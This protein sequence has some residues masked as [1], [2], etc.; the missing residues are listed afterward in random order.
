MDDYPS[1]PY[2]DNAFLQKSEDQKKEEKKEQSYVTSSLPV[3]E[4]F[5]TWLQE[6]ADFYNSTEALNVTEKTP[7]RQI[8]V[9]VLLKKGMHREFT[10]K[11][12]EF[13]TDFAEYLKEELK[14]QADD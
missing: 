2:D 11:I 14:E 5:I 8:A 12:E 7:E 10:N 1:S 13:K 6:S 3:L 9:A 4:K